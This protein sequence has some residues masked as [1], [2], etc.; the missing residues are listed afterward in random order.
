[1]GDHAYGVVAYGFDL[2][3]R[4][5]WK[6]EGAEDAGFSFPWFDESEEEGDFQEQADAL[7]LEVAGP[8]AAVRIEVMSY[9]TYDEPSYCLVARSI[10]VST[11]D[12]KVL[13]LHAMSLEVLGGNYDERLAWACK[14]LGIKPLQGQAA[15]LLVSDYG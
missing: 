7:L 9:D 11:G 14:T 13:D 15:W 10:S 1:M 8:G 12:V 4:E 3:S 6:L 2:G 5:E